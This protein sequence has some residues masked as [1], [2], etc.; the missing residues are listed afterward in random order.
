VKQSR[1]EPWQPFRR[2]TTILETLPVSR[3][4]TPQHK[5]RIRLSEPDTIISDDITEATTVTTHTMIPESPMSSDAH[6]GTP[7]V[8]IDV[9]TLVES[10]SYPDSA[11]SAA[12]A[13]DAVTLLQLQMSSL[14]RS[15][16]TMEQ[17]FQQVQILESKLD[18]VAFAVVEISTELKTEIAT[19]LVS[20]SKNNH[21]S[22]L[23]SL[24]QLMS[25]QTSQ[26]ESKMDSQNHENTKFK[27]ALERKLDRSTKSL[28]KMVETKDRGLTTVIKPKTTRTR[29][30][31]RAAC[32]RKEKTDDSMDDDDDAI[33]WSLYTFPSVPPGRQEPLCDATAVTKQK[34]PL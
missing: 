22:L 13:N 33:D 27:D 7:N 12:V 14:Q 8:P 2:A 16:Q 6:L 31:S 24:S 23:S 20:Q 17:K 25:A 21:N 32:K 3:K 4:I 28:V 30:L 15:V 18:D 10:I 34:S 5:K 26:L 9:D 11:I 1:L 29:S 19:E